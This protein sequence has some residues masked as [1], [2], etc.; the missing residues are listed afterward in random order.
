ME[1]AAWAATG[2]A[3]TM[4][5]VL[6][7]ERA[8]AAWSWPLTGL[9]LAGAGIIVWPMA[10][11]GLAAVLVL[12]A[13]AAATRRQQSVEKGGVEA[14]RARDSVGVVSFIISS[15]AIRRMRAKQ[16][17]RDRLAIGVTRNRRVRTVPLGIHQGVRGFVPGAPGAGKTVTLA[18]HAVAYIRQ[19][20]AAI[21][22]DPKGDP[23]LRD[24][25]S[26]E[27]ARVRRTFVEWTPEGSTSYNP[28][29][30]GSPSEIADKALAPEQ[31]TEPHYLRQ[32]QRYL[33]LELQTMREAKEWPPSLSRIV[34]Y[35]E[36]DR[37][38]YLARHCQGELGERVA[39]YARELAPRTRAELGGIRDRLAVLAES[40]L[41]R[42][43]EPQDGEAIDFARALARHDVVY[44]QLDA[45][46]FALASQMLGAAIVIDLVNV[47]AGLHSRRAGGLVVIDEFAAITAEQISRLLSRSRSAGLSVLI[48]T[49]SFA[50]LSVARPND[51]TDSLRRQ[52]L[53]D[54]DYVIA[55]RQSEPEAAEILGAMAGTQPAWTITRHTRSRFG[56]PIPA[57]EGTRKRTREFVCH[58]DEFKGLRVGEAIVIEPASRD[59]TSAVKV[60]PAGGAGPM[61]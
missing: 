53:S 4:G 45:D 31:F 30:R 41:G 14:R 34:H 19:G 25:L 51:Q 24:V 52:V 6:G 2:V 40:E 61:P 11:A 13:S 3:M 29:G 44:M 7:M 49:Q 60:W 12:A 58:P 46:R 57:D 50:D 39:S 9:P 26:R 22:V 23:Y 43:L 18:A 36:P 28:L 10:G 33:G 32:A 21:C 8:G 20:M 56:A 59:K 42:W 55:H 17:R 5:L 1:L 27:A 48:G 47:T 35:F 16:V 37:L 54:V 15:V 38:E